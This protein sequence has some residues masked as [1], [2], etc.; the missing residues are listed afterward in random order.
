VN[1]NLDQDAETFAEW[2]EE[3][4]RAF[5]AMLSQQFQRTTE[6]EAPLSEVPVRMRAMTAAVAKVITEAPPD[7]REGSLWQVIQSMDAAEDN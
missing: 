7:S 2:P 4:Q 1:T 6:Q 5:A 3:L